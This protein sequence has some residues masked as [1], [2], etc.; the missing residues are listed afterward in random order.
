[1]AIFQLGQCRLQKASRSGGA[2]IWS[3]CMQSVAVRI[4]HTRRG[5]TC[6][7]LFS[8]RVTAES[9][10]AAAVRA[11]VPSQ[12]IAGV[13]REFRS[14]VS[15]QQW[16]FLIRLEY[17]DLLGQ[18]WVTITTARAGWLERGLVRAS[19]TFQLRTRRRKSTSTINTTSAA[20][21]WPSMI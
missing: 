19:R 18:L 13:A 9:D 1:M 8:S 16:Q 2:V 5:W 12:A 6:T 20:K 15:N 7:Q 21:H 3:C 14:D 17:R 4:H 11:E 10:G